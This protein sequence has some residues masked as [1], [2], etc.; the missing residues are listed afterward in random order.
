MSQSLDELNQQN[1]ININSVKDN[2]LEEGKVSDYSALQTGNVEDKLKPIESYVLFISHAS[3]GQN[4]TLPL[5]R[6]FVESL[7]KEFKS[8]NV[9]IFIDFD[10][11]SYPISPRINKAL[12]A[13]RYGLLICSPRYI[14][15]I[16]QEYSY[17]ASEYGY[18]K[19]REV[20]FNKPQIIPLLFGISRAEFQTIGIPLSSECEIVE[21]PDKLLRL[22]DA[23]SIKILT[24]KIIELISRFD[25]LSTTHS[26]LP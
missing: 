6:P 11:Y 19:G 23:E 24:Q 13:S 9:K 7:V 8:T 21:A 17:I 12:K 16:D 15:R 18:F 22:I 25:N 5:E 4:E 26:Q 10:E 2:S 1:I 3:R 14:K 20:R